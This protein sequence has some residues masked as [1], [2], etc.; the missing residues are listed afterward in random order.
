ML[1]KRHITSHQQIQPSQS[2]V[3]MNECSYDENK[4]RRQDIEIYYSFVGKV[5]LPEQPP[6]LSDTRAKCRIGTA[7]FF[8]T[9]I[10]SLSHISKG[11]GHDG[12][13]AGT[14]GGLTFFDI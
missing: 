14:F 10:T 2:T 12:G 4:T 8:Y 1:N 5:D 7:K 13:C 11:V 3:K 6:D 9:S